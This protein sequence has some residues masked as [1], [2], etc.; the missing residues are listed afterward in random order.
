MSMYNMLH[1]MNPATF[2]ILPMLGKH[3]DNYPRFRDCFITDEEADVEDKIII[4]TRT[5][6]GNRDGYEAENAAMQAMPTFVRDYDDPF[7]CT[8]ANFVFDVPEEWKE[9]YD[10]ITTQRT[11]EISD[12]YKARLYEV[13]PKL[14][15]KFDKMFN[16]EEGEEE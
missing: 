9:D 5:G 15:E 6:G 13:Y 8:Y 3:P 16:P 2:L 10:K 4:Y 7:D 14:K 12:E 11:S 1:G